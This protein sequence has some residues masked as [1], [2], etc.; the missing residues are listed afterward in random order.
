Q[1]CVVGLA[2]AEALHATA[3]RAV[4]V[5]EASDEI[6]DQCGLTDPGL[7]G[8]PCQRAAARVGPR[9]GAPQRREFGLPPDKPGG[10]GTLDVFSRRSSV[11]AIARYRGLH[12]HRARHEP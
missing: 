1:D 10:G 11:L 3:T 2:S 4:D 5:I 8:D 9:P 6:L 12:G 7:A